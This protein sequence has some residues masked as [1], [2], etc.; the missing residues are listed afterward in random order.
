MAMQRAGPK[1]EQV[2]NQGVDAIERSLH[3]RSSA[4]RKVLTFEISELFDRSSRP[5]GSY[6]TS[7]LA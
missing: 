7:S 4:R 1:H 6:Q 2:M 3:M 5:G